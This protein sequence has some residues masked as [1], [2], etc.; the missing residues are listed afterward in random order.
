MK[1]YMPT[2]QSN[3]SRRKKN[4]SDHSKHNDNES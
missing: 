3:G 4:K 1:T 2:L